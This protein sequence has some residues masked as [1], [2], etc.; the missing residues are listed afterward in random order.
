[1]KREGYKRH[2]LETKTDWRRLRSNYYGLVSQV[3]AAIGRILQALQDSGAAE[4]TLL[5]YTS[6][7]GDMLGDH[8][9]VQKG[10]FYEG[11]TRVPLLLRVPWQPG[12]KRVATPFSH[13]DLAPTLLELMGVTAPTAIDGKSRAA[14]LEGESLRDDVVVVSN[15]P[16]HPDEDGRCLLTTDGWKCNLY[17]DDAPELFDLSNDP[18]ELSNVAR[19]PEHRSRLSDL[20]ARVRDW[21]QRTGDTLPLAV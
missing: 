18:A 9:L 21:Q 8:C 15:D 12:G 13:V 4:N 17:R 6:D 16:K 14:A 20:V 11:A 3:D 2:R 19:Q 1:V 7:H 10:V 5:V